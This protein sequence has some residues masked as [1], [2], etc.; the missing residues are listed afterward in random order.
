MAEYSKERPLVLRDEVDGRD[1]RY[2]A[3]YVDADGALHIDGQ[4]LGPATEMVSA[5]GEYEWF[6]TIKAAD[7]PR[8]LEALGARRDA[9]V[10]EV[11]A[12]EFVGPRSYEL[13]RRLRTSDIP[14]ER[15]VW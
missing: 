15:Y 8:L 9:P 11:L 4:D 13:E 3:A 12:A 2:L 14:I 10:M 7:L 5:D 6:Q 1:R